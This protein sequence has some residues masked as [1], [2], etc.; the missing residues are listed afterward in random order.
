MG[1]PELL[2]S[3]T[4][5]PQ[6][7][8]A[9]LVAQ[10]TAVLPPASLL[11]ERED[12][13]PFECDGMTAYQRVPLMVAL[14]ETEDQVRQVLRICYKGRVPVVFRG[15]GTGL[16][17]GALPY[18]QG[19]LLVMAKMKQIRPH[20]SRRAHRA[21]AAGRAQRGNFRGD[22]SLRP[23]LRAR[24]LQPDRLF[25]RRQRRREFRWR[26]L[27]E[28]W[29]DGPQH[30]EDCASS[31]SK[32]NC[33]RSAPRAWIRRATI[34]WRW[35]PDGRRF[36][37]NV[38]AQIYSGYYIDQLSFP[39]F[40]R[41]S[42][43]ATAMREDRLRPDM[44]QQNLGASVMYIVKNERF[45]YRAAF[46]QDAWQKRSAGSWLVGG[47]F[48]L[49][50]MTADRSAVPSAIDTSFAQALRFKRIGQL[51]VGAMGGYG[52]TFVVQQHFYFSFTGSVGLGLVRSRSYVADGD[53][54]PVRHH[55]GGNLHSQ[56]RF[57]MG[58][59]SALTSLGLSYVNEQSQ[60]SL[61]PKAVY[62]WSVGNFRLFFV[63]RFSARIPVVDAL[64]R[65]LGRL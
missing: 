65:R 49:Q 23:L 39:G 18:A 38:F 16:S 8:H 60:T 33:S 42:A 37:I 48:V 46:N 28:V 14:P 36:A 64:A 15:A 50:G 5:Q 56:A 19:L 32:A 26:A 2:S 13:K 62:G 55:W 44:R 4:L 11:H 10:L 53:A 59:N 17:G 41:D 31:P 52:H 51:E 3:E 24:S 9:D 63:Q 43:Y 1:M 6:V 34:S 29:P 12:L 45:S 25:D 21:R 54:Y 27:P 58:W 22:C 20:R 40:E 61:A 57:A 30:S 7:A 47:N 35:S